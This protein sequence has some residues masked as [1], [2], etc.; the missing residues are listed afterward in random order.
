MNEPSETTIVVDDLRALLF[1]ASVGVHV[2]RG[3]QRA[4]EIPQVLEN[5][6]ALINF[7]LPYKP[8]FQ[9]GEANHDH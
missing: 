5:Y 7:Q 2:S 9:G 6:A 1:W 8:E 4:E 3:G